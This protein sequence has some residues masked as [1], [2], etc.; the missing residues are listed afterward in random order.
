MK[1]GRAA[2]LIFLTLSVLVTP[3]GTAA[4]PA[5]KVWRIGFLGV[6]TA[7]LY[8]RQV[9]SLLL[10]LREHGYVEGRN[11]AIEFR[12]AEGRYDRLA[13][14]AAELVSLKPDVII[15][16]GGPGT[17]A[18]KGATSTIPVV[19]AIIG[20][21]VEV[22]AV[23]S[24]ARPGGNITGSSFLFQE[25]N[26][27]RL[28]LDGLG[29]RRL[30]AVAGPSYGGFQAFQ[31]A[32]TY[33]EFMRGIVAVV[34]APKMPGGP[35]GLRELTDRFAT[36]PHWNGGWHY[37]RGGIPATLTALRIETLKRYGM[38]EILA[39]GIPDPAQ[40]ERRIREMAEAWAREFD[41]NSMVTLRKAR[42]GF[43]TERDFGK[44]RAKVLYVLSRTDKLFPPSIAPGV[45]NRLRAAGVEA[46][47]VEIDGE[48]GHLA[49]GR[50]WAKWAPALRDFAS[51][52]D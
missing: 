11:T 44:I 6:A 35:E 16:H 14:L 19:M 2:L 47:Y 32:V 23:A 25:V 17:L 36:D 31:W 24:L 4:Q 51:S 30:V 26:A 3:L 7:T 28:L 49:S 50:D 5:A 21:P 40:R 48:F 8:E 1:S 45:M 22:G 42:I 41:P 29:A 27:Q 9:E 43:D 34:T 12:W 33:P 15:T 18:V 13:A 37:D 10:G 20:N 38:N 46:R 52:L 39:V